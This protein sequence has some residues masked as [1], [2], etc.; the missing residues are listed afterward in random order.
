MA[1]SNLDALFKDADPEIAT[2]LDRALSEKEITTEEAARLY[3]A[4]G[5][6]FQYDQ[7]S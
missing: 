2:T 5:M 7:T 1:L 3:E 4:R 6:D